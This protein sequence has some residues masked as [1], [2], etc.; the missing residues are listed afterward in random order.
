[1][2][3]FIGA[4]IVTLIVAL[5]DLTIST[6]VLF[7]S[8][9]ASAFILTHSHSHHLTKLRT[10][11][12]AYILA[13]IISGVIFILT[14]KLNLPM[15]LSAFL[16]ILFVSLALYLFDAVHPPAVSASFSFILFDAN[17]W[18]LLYLFVSIVI[19][20]V[21]VRLMTYVFSQNLSL[22][23]FIQEFKHSNK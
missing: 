21:L 15:E 20:L 16:L 17:L 14:H 2:P 13:I 4:L 10:T 12:K 22:K 18:L 1:M 11:I 5:F 19:L 3:S 6:I 23:S 9:A 7:G 8:V